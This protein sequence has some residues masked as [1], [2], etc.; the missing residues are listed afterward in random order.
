MQLEVHFK[1]KEQF[2]E[3]IPFIKTLFDK[4]TKLSGTSDNNLLLFQ[5]WEN[6]REYSVILEKTK[7]DPCL[8]HLVVITPSD[9]TQEQKEKI[10]GVVNEEKNNLEDEKM[11]REMLEKLTKPKSWFQKLLG[12]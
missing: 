7:L 1:D 12:L 6:I 8:L 9:I 10:W 11:V 2:E 4:M 3:L 5:R